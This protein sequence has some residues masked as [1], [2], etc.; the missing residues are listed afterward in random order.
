MSQVRRKVIDIKPEPQSKPAPIM[1][2]V[3]FHKSQIEYGTRILCLGRLTPNAI[4]RVTMIESNFLGSRLG[5]IK[6]KKVN[7]IRYLSDVITLKSEE[8]GEV[9]KM[10]FIYLSYSA[11]WRLA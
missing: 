9:R 10:T 3:F 2:D 5:D 7:Q 11:I 1:D 6:L 8:T 4:W